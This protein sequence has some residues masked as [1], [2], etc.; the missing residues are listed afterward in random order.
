MTKVQNEC[1]AH[2]A[3]DSL[4]TWANIS[5]KCAICSEFFLNMILTVFSP[6]YSQ[7]EL[8]FV[9]LRFFK[10]QHE[11]FDHVDLYKRATMSESLWLPITKAQPWAM[12]FRKERKC[13]SLKKTRESQFR[14][15]A[16]KNR[17]TNSQP[18]HFLTYFFL[19]KI[20]TQMSLKKLNLMRENV[21]FL[22]LVY[23]KT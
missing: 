6:F 9:P 13:D 22:I 15:L 19:K 11:Q 7:S 3:S 23:E 1:F 21:T 2:D 16:H 18:C 12:L 4:V 17:W 20:H 14:Y 8:L 10:E 5:K